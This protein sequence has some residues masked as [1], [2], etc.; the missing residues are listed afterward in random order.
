MA[1]LKQVSLRNR[2]LR[3]LS[4]DDFALIEPQLDK[5]ATEKGQV[6][7]EPDAPIG[8]VT[9]PEA[10]IV[11][12]VAVASENQ[13]V[14]IGIA[15]WEGLIGHPVVL[16]VDH[17]PH[18]SFVQVEGFGYRI[19]AAHLTRAI[20]DSRSL[21]SLLLRSVHAFSIQ[22]AG[23]AVAN[24]ESV[25]SERLAR[26][27]LM[28]HD[29]IDGDDLP[30]TH[31]FLSIMLAVRRAGVTEA[32]HLLEGAGIIT[33]KRAFITVVDRDRLEDTAGDSYGQPEAEYE[34]LFPS[35]PGSDHLRLVPQQKD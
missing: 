13:R 17:T 28:C 24:S 31:E 7:I 25:I 29:R 5:V 23:T 34:R 14:E 3:A 21:H 32:I 1:R 33:A 30:L 12:V 9:F 2:L 10:G 4:P 20:E 22:V 8:H 15:G 26:W 19:A 16:G 27:L 6:L 35:S 11:S 18:Q